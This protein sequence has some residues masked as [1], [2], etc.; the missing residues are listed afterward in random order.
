MPPDVI[1]AIWQGDTAAE[2]GDVPWLAVLQ[3]K[4]IE[5]EPPPEGI[6]VITP[7]SIKAAQKEDASICEVTNLKKRGW[8]PNDKDK[9]QMCRETRRLVHEWNKLTLDKGILY[10]QIGQRKQLVL[11]SKLKSTVLKHLHDDMGHVGADKVIHLVRESFYWPAPEKRRKQRNSQVYPSETVDRESEHSDDEEEYTYCLR[12][13]PVYERRKVSARSELG[14]ELRAVAPEF[15]PVR[16][17]TETAQMQRPHE[18]DPVSVPG[19][20]QIAIPATTPP[21]EGQVR[22]DIMEAVVEEQGDGEHVTELPEEEMPSV[23]RSTRAMKPRE[24]LTY[25]H[26]G[27]PSYQP[28]RPGVNMMVACVP[29]SMS[30]FPAIPEPCYY[31]VPIWTY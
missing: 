9:R 29:Y 25:N 6:P 28:W 26:F 10:R 7:E 22:D 14:N 19:S 15:Q 24:L 12:S 17:V 1:S 16:R 31:P 5:D 3:L 21:A 20:V 30:C 2:D 27:Q 18:L 13:I 23:R 8:N 4:P 11:P